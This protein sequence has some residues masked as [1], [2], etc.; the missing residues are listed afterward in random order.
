MST[1]R[2]TPNGPPSTSSGGKERGGRE[3]WREE[4]REIERGNKKERE[5]ERGREGEREKE[6]GGV[7]DM[8]REN[9]KE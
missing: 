6:R 8:Y 5:R 7:G 4:G 9:N 3:K 2:Q 1:Y